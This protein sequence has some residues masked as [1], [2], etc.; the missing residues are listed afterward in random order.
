MRRVDSVCAQC[1]QL[2]LA[3]LALAAPP[4]LGQPCP[5]YSPP[6]VSGTVATSALVEASGLA[7]SRRNPGV[8]W[9]HNDSGNSNRVYALGLDGADLGTFTLSGTTN[10]D[11]E[12]M[13]IGCGPEPGVD[14]LYVGDIGDNLNFRPTIRVYRVPEPAVDPGAPAGNVTLRGV[15][16]I[17]LAYPDGP[18][19]AESLMI[20]VNGDL[21]IV[22]KR[23]SAH[24][25]VY[26][27]AF[28]QATSGTIM[29]EFVAEIPWGAVDG[30]GGATGGDIAHDGSAVIVRRGSGYFPAATLWRRAP[31]TALAT[32][33]AQPGC[34]LALPSEPQGE[35]ICFAPEDLSLYTLSEGAHPPIHFLAQE[36]IVG[37]ING[38]GSVTIDDLLRVIAA[39]GPCPPPP[40]RCVAD[41]NNTAAVDIDDLLL[42][43]SHWG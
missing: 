29:L 21:Y 31:G 15:Q 26:R 4:A 36:K 27:A 35:A 1:I 34:D 18:R 14:Y 2:A 6:T 11:W 7:A 32:V 22:S 19:D 9:S 13:A 16:T 3:A 5:E 33:F 25:R 37:D 41:V 8:L 39:W 23:V 12:D 10:F 40:I 43:I 28:P 38:D 42:V 17:T 20:D 30:S 24:G